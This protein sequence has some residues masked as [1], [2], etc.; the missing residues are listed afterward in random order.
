[1]YANTFIPLTAEQRV[2]LTTRLADARQSYHQLAIGNAAR[3]IV[4]QNGE[5]VEFT[6]SNKGTLAAY[7]VSLESQLSQVPAALRTLGPAG[8]IF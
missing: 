1:M 3:V 7:I 6:A 5:R 2:I 8:F 4:D